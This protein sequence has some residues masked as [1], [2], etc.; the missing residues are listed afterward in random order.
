ML[1]SQ[2]MG[3]LSVIGYKTI[4]EEGCRIDGKTKN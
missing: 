1:T 4:I 2:R 3:I